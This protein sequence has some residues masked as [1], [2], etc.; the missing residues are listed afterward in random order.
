MQ[1]SKKVIRTPIPVVDV[2]IRVD[3]G[4]ILIKRKKQPRGWALCGG[5]ILEGERAEETAAREA[6]QETSLV[7]DNIQQFGVYSDPDRD[8]RAHTISIVFTADGN[9]FPVGDNDSEDI[10]IFT[11][12]K[13]PSPLAFDHEEIL[14]DY[15]ESVQDICRDE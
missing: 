10:G 11:E 15:F 13:L 9:G 12:D 1:K 5:I 4:I 14:Q 7:V 3:D 2:I 8:P 6:L